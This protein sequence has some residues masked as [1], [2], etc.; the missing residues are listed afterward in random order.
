MND[1]WDKMEGSVMIFL[2]EKKVPVVSRE[3]YGALP[4]SAVC[5]TVLSSFPPFLLL[6][7]KDII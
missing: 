2:A 5:Y 6:L 7:P 1:F 3:F 4:V